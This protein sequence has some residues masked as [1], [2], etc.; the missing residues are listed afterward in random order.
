MVEI[1]GIGAGG[2]AAVPA[3][4]A[5]PAVPAMPPVIELTTLSPELQERV[6]RVRQVQGRLLAR[7]SPVVALEASALAGCAAFV[8][9]VASGW[10]VLRT[11]P[12]LVTSSDQRVVLTLVGGVFALTVIAG[13][14]GYA[15]AR[16]RHARTIP[17]RGR[18]GARGPGLLVALL[19]AGGVL[20]TVQP[21]HFPPTNVVSVSAL[22]VGEY[23]ALHQVVGGAVLF[24]KG[25]T[26]V[27]YLHT[28]G[29][30]W[31]EATLPQSAVAA[32]VDEIG[33]SP[34]MTYTRGDVAPGDRGSATASH[35]TAG[36]VAVARGRRGGRVDR[37]VHVR[38]APS[39][40]RRP[41]ARAHH[42]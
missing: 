2:G 25:N 5:M 13:T 20:L 11:V 39:M 7:R 28:T 4:A 22:R 30:S 6:D 27:A 3:S 8:A 33:V 10:L 1:D 12:T 38:R 34:D 14:A 37:G 18:V 42:R 26:P 15:T 35:Q 9:G 29:G 19:G 36:R 16:W 23:L 40:A 32:V 41:V 31:V 24:G 21:W 17:S